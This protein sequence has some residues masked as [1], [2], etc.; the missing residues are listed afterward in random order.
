MN[1]V[2]LQRVTSGIAHLT[3]DTCL[4]W[5]SGAQ[6]SCRS[7]DFDVFQCDIAGQRG[8]DV[9]QPSTLQEGPKRCTCATQ[10]T[11]LTSLATDTRLVWRSGVDA[12]SRGE[13]TYLPANCRRAAT[14]RCQQHWCRPH[15]NT[16]G[17]WVI[18]NLL[19]RIYMCSKLQKGCR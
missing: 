11:L 1:T 15:L 17:L 12:S 13:L 8:A 18:I 5:R 19:G 3:S 14:S 6:N 4:V 7:L 9:T 10:I 2:H 16:R